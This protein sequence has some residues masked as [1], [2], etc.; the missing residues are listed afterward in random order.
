[1]EHS[2]SLISNRAILSLGKEIALKY[3]RQAINSRKLVGDPNIYTTIPCLELIEVPISECCSYISNCTV[4]RSKYRLPKIAGSNYGLNIEG[5]RT[6]QNIKMQPSTPSQYENIVKLK[7]RNNNIYYWV[8]NDHLYVS[9][10]D[11]ALVSIT[12][13]FEGEVEDY[14]L[15]CGDTDEDDCPE[16][17][18][19]QDFKAPSYM[20]ADIKKETES[21]LLATYK[22]SIDDQGNPGQ[23]ESR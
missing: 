3:I 9:S 6:M 19:D 18:Y 2:D 22:R 11:I 8:F 7:L 10:P 17:P 12:A 4:A 16:N 23:E 15:K 5:V 13:L 14:L 21:L 20:L 1:M